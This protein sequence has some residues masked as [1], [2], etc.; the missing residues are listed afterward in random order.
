[1]ASPNLTAGFAL[2]L[3]LTIGRFA[4]LGLGSAA[5]RHT[6]PGGLFQGFLLCVQATPQ[7]LVAARAGACYLLPDSSIP[8]TPHGT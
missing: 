4:T 1:M 8:G 2:H 5:L 3:Q 6:Q 7:A